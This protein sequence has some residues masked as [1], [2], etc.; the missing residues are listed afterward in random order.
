MGHPA[1]SKNKN[2]ANKKFPPQKK[3]P[4]LPLKTRE[5]VEAELLESGEESNNFDSEVR[6]NQ[7]LN[8]NTFCIFKLAPP[9]ETN[10]GI[11]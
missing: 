10:Q 3:A 5:Q 1:G 9:F 11:L 8:Q 7:T 2:P 4:C 6:D